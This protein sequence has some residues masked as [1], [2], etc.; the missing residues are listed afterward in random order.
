MA[1]F[2]AEAARR[3]EE[4]VPEAPKTPE[5]PEAPETSATDAAELAR[6]LAAASVHSLARLNAMHL[7][8]HRHIIESPCH[9]NSGPGGSYT[10]SCENCTWD[11]QI[12]TCDCQTLAGALNRTATM[13]PCRSGYANDDGKL[14]CE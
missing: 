9:V 13:T 4:A 1:H 7:D 14:R 8:Y 5:A 6:A 12:L 10:K 3:A 11:G 2:E